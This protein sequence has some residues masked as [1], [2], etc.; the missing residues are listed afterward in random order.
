[1]KYK[2][3]K[4]LIKII[5]KFVFNIR[6]Y[7]RDYKAQ[8]LMII[9]HNLSLNPNKTGIKKEVE[10]DHVVM[11][12][13]TFP[14]RINTVYLS[15]ETIMRQEIKPNKIILYLTKDEFP[16]QREELP[17]SLIKLES[18]GLEIRF[19]DE[20]LRS[21]N[22]L[23][24]ALKEFPNSVIITFDDDCFYTR[25]Y[26][27]RLLEAHKKNPKDIIGYDAM[28]IKF[29]KHKKIKPYDEWFDYLQTNEARHDTF[30][31]SVN[32]ILYPPHPFS[33]EAFNTKVIKEISL[34]NDDIWFKAMAILNG[35]KHR[36]LENKNIQFPSIPS[37]QE[38][39]L[40]HENVNNNRND[41]IISDVFTK[42]KI[43]YE[44]IYG[45]N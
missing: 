33:K 43:N 40:F 39:G 23:I 18:R 41:K 15:I 6:N 5:P 24:H 25:D 22:K 9:Y 45:T 28:Q 13:T 35:T 3:K 32:G 38:S 29:N 34:F 20:N 16:K 19:T 2:T 27:K 12:T 37:T 4:T 31:L 10:N 11:S 26:T 42:Y 21:N 7:F 44:K 17:E 30:L 14:A 8:D 36:R 1:M